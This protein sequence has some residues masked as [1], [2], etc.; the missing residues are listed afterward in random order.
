MRIFG[1]F[2]FLLALGL[3]T[4]STVCIPT[5]PVKPKIVHEFAEFFKP[6]WFYKIA[7]DVII[8]GARNIFLCF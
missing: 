4:V 8:V 3:V 2:L 1:S 6:H 7:I 5:Q